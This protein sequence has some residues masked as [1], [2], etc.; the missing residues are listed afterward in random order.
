MKK[1]FSMF[2][3]RVVLL[4]SLSITF[5]TGISKSGTNCSVFRSDS[6]VARFDYFSYKWN[7]DFYKNNLL[8]RNNCFYNSFLSGWFSDPGI[9]NNGKDCFL[10]TS[11][12]SHFLGVSLFHCT[13]M[14]NY[15]QS[16]YIL[17]KIKQ[18]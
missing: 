11:I 5:S 12:F 7:N 13:D 16:N 3:Y 15:K 1:G 14:V 2:I 9:C 4:C 17:S 6:L 8:P 18:L 10:V